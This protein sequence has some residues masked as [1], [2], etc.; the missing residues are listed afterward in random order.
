MYLQAQ[1]GTTSQLIGDLVQIVW[2]GMALGVAYGLTA[3]VTLQFIKDIGFR[4]YFNRRRF[5]AWMGGLRGSQEAKTQLVWLAAAGDERMLFS[6][7][8]DKMAGQI[9]VAANAILESPKNYPELIRLLGRRSEAERKEEANRS[10]E[11]AGGATEESK[12]PDKKERDKDVEYLIKNPPET[13]RGT[14]SE[15]NSDKQMEYAD[16]RTRVSHRIQRQIDLLQLR[17]EQEWT[18]TNRYLAIFVSAVIGMAPL[19]LR[20]WLAGHYGA[21]RLIAVLPASIV[22][23]LIGGLLA[24]LLRDLAARQSRPE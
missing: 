19:Y 13:L 21:F 11:S 7:P 23:S 2:E 3:M 12:E 4:E 18:A 5:N 20:G 9:G 8:I 16:A 6:L 15:S 24:P 1:S 10:T 22:L 14:Q 17:S